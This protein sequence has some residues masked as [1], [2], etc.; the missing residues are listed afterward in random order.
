MQNLQ[1][2]RWMKIPYWRLDNLKQCKHPKGIRSFL[3]SVGCK[4]KLWS[5]IVAMGYRWQPD[6]R[7][8][9]HRHLGYLLRYRKPPHGFHQHGGR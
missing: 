6:A 3:E 7:E 9:E 4:R 1:N 8:D 2:T 5:C